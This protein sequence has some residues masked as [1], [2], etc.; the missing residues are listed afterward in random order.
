MANKREVVKNLHEKYIKGSPAKAVV[1]NR[2]VFLCHLTNIVLKEIIRYCDCGSK[3]Y[4]NTRVL[5]HIYDKKPAE[6]FEF[7]INNIHMIVKYPDYIYENKNPKRGD[8]CLIKQIKGENYFCSVEIIEDE[9][10]ETQ[11]SEKNIH[12]ATAFRIRKASYLNAYKSLWS[13]KDGAPSS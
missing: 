12:I 13:W 8:F 4:I 5:K 9:I 6:E 2:T 10:P 11:E 7:L 1:I 3:A